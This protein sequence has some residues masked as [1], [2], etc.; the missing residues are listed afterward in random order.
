MLGSTPS[1]MPVGDTGLAPISLYLVT[2]RPLRVKV[3]FEF[4]AA[5]LAWLGWASGNRALRAE[6]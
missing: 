1:G 5:R 6:D 3:L 4:L 2:P